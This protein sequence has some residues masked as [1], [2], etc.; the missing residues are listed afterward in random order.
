M[1]Q[2]TKSRVHSGVGIACMEWWSWWMM[3]DFIQN[4][5]RAIL[6]SPFF[7]THSLYNVSCTSQSSRN[8]QSPWARGMSNRWK[9]KLAKRTKMNKLKVQSLQITNMDARSRVAPSGDYV[10]LAPS[11]DCNQSIPPKSTNRICCFTSLTVLLPTSGKLARGICEI[12]KEFF[13]S[14]NSNIIQEHSRTSNEIQEHSRVLE[15]KN[16]IQEHSRLSATCANPGPRWLVR[17]P[18]LNMPFLPNS[19]FI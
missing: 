4:W 8:L 16:Q 15:W 19:E 18:H 10:L 6:G 14:F 11:G 5:H 1:H 17:F 9:G 7:T 3:P 2:L 13:F 12:N